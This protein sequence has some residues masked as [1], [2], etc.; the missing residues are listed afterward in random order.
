MHISTGSKALDALLGGGV[1]TGM[2]TDVYGPAGS[3]KS[4]LCFTLCANCAR[5]QKRVFFIDTAGTF[6]P[7]RISEIAG[8]T[9]IL[10]Y[11][12]VTRA[13]GTR[14]QIAALDRIDD[15]ALVVVDSLTSLFSAEYSGPSR[16]LAVM[17][18]MH[19]LA[20][21]AINAPCAVVATN[22]VRAVPQENGKSIEREYLAATV[23][24]QAHM[25]L[26]FA[27]ENAAK[28]SYRAT[29]VQPPRDSAQFLISR[30]GIHDM[31]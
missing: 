18:H 5:E 22:M 25:R 19:E 16:H 2:L 31:D 28:S 7:E 17:S 6:R 26:K 9:D 3:G 23:S 14:D 30:S 4:Q 20:L 24:I 13:L 21:L 15:A 12:T 1:R 29:L 27:V 10:D 8:N 11:I